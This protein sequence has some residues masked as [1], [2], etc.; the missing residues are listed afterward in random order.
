MAAFL[1]VG[2]TVLASKIAQWS[3]RNRGTIALTNASDEPAVSSE[4]TLNKITGFN[5]GE[6]TGT[7]TVDRLNLTPGAT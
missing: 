4:A 5:P 7:L 3:D 2:G 6:S 1:F